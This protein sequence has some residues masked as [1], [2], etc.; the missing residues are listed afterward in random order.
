MKSSKL[1]LAA[2]AMLIATSTASMAYPIGLN[3]LG[4]FGLWE[5]SFG[6]TLMPAG[7]YVQVWWS[8]D[9]SYGQANPG[10][11]HLNEAGLAQ[12]EMSATYGDY[13]L[14]SG[15]T[16]DDGGWSGSQS[17]GTYTDG[18]VGG[19]TISSGH[20]YIYAYNSPAPT[21]G[22]MG[23]MTVLYGP[24][25]VGPGQKVWADMNADPPPLAD[26]IP[27]STDEF[28]GVLTGSNGFVVVPEPGTMA[29]LGIGMLTIA[30]RRRRKSA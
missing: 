30:A 2:A 18:N 9:A 6:S 13:V 8:A 27:M 24:N 17:L 29:L 5:D 20:V 16:P 1:S 14:W 4:G 11:V 25:A 3:I 21:V 7:G 15:V 12:G 22:T 10:E 28:D 23:V 19:N 26:D